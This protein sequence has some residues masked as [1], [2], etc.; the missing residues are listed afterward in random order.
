MRFI[1]KERSYCISSLAR[2]I[3]NFC[4]HHFHANQMSWAMG[5]LTLAKK[6]TFPHGYIPITKAIYRDWNI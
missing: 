2:Q 1:V 5:I 4:L 6:E 3:K